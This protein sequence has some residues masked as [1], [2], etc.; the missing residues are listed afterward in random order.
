MF[1]WSALCYEASSNIAPFAM[2][3]MGATFS[4]FSVW[5]RAG[6]RATPENGA[7]HYSQLIH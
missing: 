6:V 2:V 3:T 4:H 1:P 5:S 7:R